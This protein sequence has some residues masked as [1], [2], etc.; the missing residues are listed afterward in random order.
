MGYCDSKQASTKQSPYY[1]LY[2]QHMRLPIG[3]EMIPNPEQEEEVDQD[4]AISVLLI[5]MLS[6]LVSEPR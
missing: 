1:M 5:Q 2:Q 3:A 6:T 4:A